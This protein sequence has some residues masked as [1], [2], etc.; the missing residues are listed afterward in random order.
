MNRDVLGGE[1]RED[2]YRQREQHMQ[3]AQESVLDIL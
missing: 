2:N 1:V 3:S